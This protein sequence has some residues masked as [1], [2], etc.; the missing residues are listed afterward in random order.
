[1]KQIIIKGHKFMKTTC[2]LC[3]CVFKFEEEDIE[4]HEEIKD[5]GVSFAT[6]YKL[7]CPYCKKQITVRDTCDVENLW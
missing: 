6:D 4:Q 7:T 3:G 1:M 5:K 2:K